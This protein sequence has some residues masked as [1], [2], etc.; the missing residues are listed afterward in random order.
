M[1][2][3]VAR[4]RAKL[5]KLYGEAVRGVP[6]RLSRVPVLGKPIE[7]ASLA[8]A[9]YRA[10]RT[11]ISSLPPVVTFALTT[12]C[13]TKDICVICD[14]NG[15]DARIDFDSTE[16]AITAVMPIL[17]TASIV[18][19][20]CGG[21]PLFSQHFDVV[22][23][24]MEPPT[25]VSFATNGMALTPGRAELMLKRDIMGDIVI[26]LD[27]ATE[28]TLRIMRPACD[29]GVLA[30]NVSYYVQRA[31]SLGRDAAQVHFS[32]TLCNSNLRD[33][34]LL[35]DLAEEWGATHVQYNH[36][37]EG[38][39]HTVTTTEGRKWVY[40]DQARI[41]DT[42]LHDRLLLEAYH[43]AKAKGIGIVFVG[44]PFI[45]PDQQAIPPEIK[46][47]IRSKGNLVVQ[48]AR[49][50][51]WKSGFHKPLSPELPVCA[52]PWQEIVIQPD[53]LVRGCYF[54]DL[55]DHNLGSILKIDF[56]QIWNS[57]EMIK[58]REQFLS[59][60]VSNVCLA[61]HPCLFR[62]RE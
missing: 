45:G 25:R 35:V 5:K 16:E 10:G 34:P 47:D 37:N 12:Q 9:E 49:G 6:T 50:D 54:H 38:L 2:E 58:R 29:F 62:G 51:V 57:E 21:E 59:Q 32:M 3:T 28:E 23:Q 7:N 46:S 48:T 14:H 42:A 41:T 1:N 17:K 22:I 18:R 20:H 43:R 30:S 15:R 36:L 26:S 61:S 56:M 53:G 19:L 52:K 24:A 60:G 4:A 8:Y 11:A 33:I 44:K 39:S 40:A 13:F 31:K 55:G 27:A